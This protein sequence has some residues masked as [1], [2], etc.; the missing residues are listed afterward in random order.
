MCIAVLSV[1]GFFL[2]LDVY[3][4]VNAHADKFSSVYLAEV[5]L[6]VMVCLQRRLVVLE[7]GCWIITRLILYNCVDK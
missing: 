7:G 2:S 4:Y 5:A 6:L 3:M 1:F